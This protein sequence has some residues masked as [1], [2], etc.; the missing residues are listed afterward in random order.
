M[1]K[2]VCDKN[3]CRNRGFD[4]FYCEDCFLDIERQLTEARKRIVELETELCK[5][6]ENQGMA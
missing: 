1:L 5:L 2:T 3:G 6:Q 4:I